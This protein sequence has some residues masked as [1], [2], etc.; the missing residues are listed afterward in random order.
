MTQIVDDGQ[1]F[2]YDFDRVNGSG[3]LDYGE[4]FLLGWWEWA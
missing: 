1:I 4:V 3:T 2:E